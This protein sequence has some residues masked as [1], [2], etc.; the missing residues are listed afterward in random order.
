M[1]LKL[2]L[3]TILNYCSGVD[4]NIRDKYGFSA[5]YWSKQNGHKEIMDFLPNPL[6]ISK[7]EFMENMKAT[8]AAHGIKPGGKKKKGKK[9]KKKK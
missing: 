3:L 6:A 9:G 1:K 5:S 7:E 2:V 8:W 4:P